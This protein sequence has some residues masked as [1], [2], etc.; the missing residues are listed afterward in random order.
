M[1]AHPLAQL[2][3][4]TRVLKRAQYEAF[5]FKLLDQGLL[6]RNGSHPDP[7]NHEYQVT[8]TDGLPMHCEC[9]ADEKYDGA[10]KHCV[11]VAIRNPV[12]EAAVHA[13]L[14]ADGSGTTDRSLS[15]EQYLAEKESPERVD[16][17]DELV[18]TDGESSEDTDEEEHPC[19]CDSLTNDFPCWNCVL[20]G[21]RSV[22]DP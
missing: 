5:E 9:P 21:R 3:V 15:K 11:A 16:V 14:A 4:S 13:Q 18:D 2:D 1:P 22:P 8:V 6:V 17:T 19:E 12:L 20:A 7:E 10:C